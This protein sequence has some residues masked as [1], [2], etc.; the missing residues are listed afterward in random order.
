MVTL[1]TRNGWYRV[2]V[3][4][5]ASYREAQSNIKSRA[6]AIARESHVLP[7]YKT[8]DI[9]GTGPGDHDMTVVFQGQLNTRR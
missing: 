6:W 9:M 1:T 2:A 4:I 3:S 8:A 5:K 7:A